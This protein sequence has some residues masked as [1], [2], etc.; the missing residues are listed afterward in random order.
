MTDKLDLRI[1][2]AND[3]N[4]GGGDGAN[5]CVSL[6]LIRTFADVSSWNSSVGDKV[7][8]S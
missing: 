7:R 4:G 1:Q 3:F 8:A 2:L 6:L 5:N